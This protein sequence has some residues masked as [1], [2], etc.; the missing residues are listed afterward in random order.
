MTRGGPV[1]HVSRLVKAYGGLRP[2]RIES[3]AVGPSERVAVTGLDAPAAEVFVTLLT[4][5]GLPD[6]GEIRIDGR[7]TAD[8]SDGDEWLASLDRFGIV[9]SRAVL[10]EELT[11]EQNLAMPF[12]LEIDPV[13]AA[14]RPRVAAL[15]EECGIELRWLVSRA[16][17]VP[18]AIRVRAHVARG[19]ALDPRL[20]ILEHPTAA[21]E[22]A[23]RAPL[24]A[25]VARITAGRKLAALVLTMDQAF[26][27][28]CADRVLALQPATG[29]LKPARK[30]WFW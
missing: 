30:G 21:T 27:E 28:G 25:D 1:L 3:L 2:L 4:G 23:D 5:A 24:A 14:L 22:P 15:A 19:I 17:D 10:L 13:P 29:Q 18:P 26:A 12:T 6:H 7:S 11:V 8:I 20:L 16:G 9:S